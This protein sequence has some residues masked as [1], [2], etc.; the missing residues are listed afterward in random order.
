M[1]RLELRRAFRRARSEVRKSE[2]L[3]CVG[4]AYYACDCGMSRQVVLCK[5]VIMREQLPSD[6]GVPA[7]VKIPCSYCDGEAVYVD[8]G[9]A[10]PW[11]GLPYLRIPSRRA[12]AELMS[13]GSFE[14]QFVE[15]TSWLSKA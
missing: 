1:D 6:H 14:A 4:L 8:S 2:R 3:E 10:Q 13:A 11:P 5:G 9:E 12:M 15:K 7:P